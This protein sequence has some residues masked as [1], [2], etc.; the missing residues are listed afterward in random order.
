MTDPPAVLKVDRD[1]LKITELSN[2]DLSCVFHPFLQLFFSQGVCVCGV[3][4]FK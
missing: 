2:I 4:S 1:S 3:Y